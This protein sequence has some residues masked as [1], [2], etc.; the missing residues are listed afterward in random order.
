MTSTQD[1]R[2]KLSAGHFHASAQLFKTA[3]FIL[4]GGE[5]H[6]LTLFSQYDAEPDGKIST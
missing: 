1:Y 2:G 4:L 3:Y 6:L 5:T